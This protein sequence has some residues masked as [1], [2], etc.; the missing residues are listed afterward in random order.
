MY[1]QLLNNYKRQNIIT[2][3]YSCIYVDVLLE[4]IHNA[5]IIDVGKLKF[6]APPYECSYNIRS[7]LIYS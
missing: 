5:Y 7:C 1:F 6:I 2:Y 4:N 3:S